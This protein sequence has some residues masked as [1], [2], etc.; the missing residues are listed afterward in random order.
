MKHYFLLLWPLF[1][2]TIEWI[3]KNKKNRYILEKRTWNKQD[4]QMCKE[5]KIWYFLLTIYVL[6]VFCSI[7]WYN[8]KRSQK[9]RCFEPRCASHNSW[10]FIA[11]CHCMVDLDTFFSLFKITTFLVCWVFIKWDTAMMENKKKM[12][13]VLYFISSMVEDDDDNGDGFICVSIYSIPFVFHFD[14]S[15]VLF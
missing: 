12:N 9:R 15:F 13:V 11:S 10:I 4:V 2:E 5:F 7:K 8:K 1:S 6:I 14:W 3:F